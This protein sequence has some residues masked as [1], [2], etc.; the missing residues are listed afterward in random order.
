M[1]KRIIYIILALLILLNIIF[2]VLNNIEKNNTYIILDS[3]N[4]WK[5]YSNGSIK[6][7]D[8]NKIKKVSY[9][10]AKLYS[11]DIEDGYFGSVQD[12]KFYNKSL[13]TI[14]GKN[15]S[16]IVVGNNKIVNYSGNMVYGTDADTKIIINYFKKINK[17]YNL[18]ATET[19]IV[20]IDDSK[21]IYSIVTREDGGPS[22]DPI[23]VIFLYNNGATTPIYQNNKNN[24]KVS[25]LDRVLDLDNDAIPE[26]VLLSG[27]TGYAGN[28][29]YSL[30]K[31][32]KTANQYKPVIKCKEE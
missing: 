10:E 23:S 15:N 29:C 5:L 8:K 11:N 16:F 30:Y 2:F 6:K 28:E 32:N 4:I 26:I 24:K 18:Y 22:D 25:T 19:K 1:K 12:Y 17:K 13:N 14:L 31:Y 27:Q 9:S 21:K 20:H 3:K 7:V